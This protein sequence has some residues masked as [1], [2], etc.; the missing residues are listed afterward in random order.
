MHNKSKNTDSIYK[1][2][3]SGDM[4]E[5]RDEPLLGFSDK[6]LGSARVIGPTRTARVLTPVR[7]YKRS[8]Y[9]SRSI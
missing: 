7:D 2:V 5:F 3:N 4:G 9:H 6:P 8:T 1:S